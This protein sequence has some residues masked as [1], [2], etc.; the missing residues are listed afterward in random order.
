MTDHTRELYRSSSG[1]RWL[2][3]KES[4][5]NRAYI[6][7]EGNASSGGHVSEIDIGSFL[8]NGAHGPEHQALM[9]LI[10][11]LVGANDDEAS[12]A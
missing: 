9:R 6:R 4:S 11:S 12:Q 7:H 1:D 5:S 8:G 2:L 10:G 3:A